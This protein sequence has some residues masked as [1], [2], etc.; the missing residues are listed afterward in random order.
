MKL[1]YT[2]GDSWTFGEEIPETSDAEVTRYYNT[3]PWHLCQLTEI[4]LCYN[5]AVGGGSNDRIFRRTTEFIFKWIG[6]QKN[7]KDLTIILGWSTPERTEVSLKDRHC[8]ITTNAVLDSTASQVRKYQNVYYSVYNDDQGILKQI[9]YMLTLRMFCQNLG[10]T[11]YDFIAMGDQPEIY[12][13]ISVDKF[14]VPLT[15]LYGPNTWKKHVF[16]NNDPVYAHGH[17]TIETQKIWA[18]HL[19]EFFFK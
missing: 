6:K 18:E 14:N 19:K 8:R 16:L 10:I 3:W 7:P 11:Y 9:R 4:P 15:N 17:P 12:N 13:N 2:N 5:D 1:L